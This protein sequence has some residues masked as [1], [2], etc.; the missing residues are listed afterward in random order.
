MTVFIYQG[1]TP[2]CGELIQ[3][4]LHLVLNNR[5]LIAGRDMTRRIGIW[6]DY[7]SA[8]LV[9]L[10]NERTT[11]SEVESGRKSTTRMPFP[12]VHTGSGAQEWDDHYSR[13]KEK[14]T[15]QL[16][17]YYKRI[18]YD[19]ERADQIMIFGPDEARLELKREM[20]R[21]KDILPKLIGVER[22]AP[23]TQEQVIAKIKKSFL[24]A[25]IAK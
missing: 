18:I 6:I 25:E 15:K 10:E 9:T 8:I 3:V 17:K 11:V 13:M 24:S 20:R 23:M 4:C 16:H 5:I 7:E 19:L 22:T 14:Q 1:M 2:V 12:A 21:F